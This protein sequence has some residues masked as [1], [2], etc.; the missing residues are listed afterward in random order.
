MN[1]LILLIGLVGVSEDSIYTKVYQ[2][3]AFISYLEIGYLEHGKD[4]EGQLYH[5]MKWSHLTGFSFRDEDGVWLLT[6]GHAIIYDINHLHDPHVAYFRSDTKKV[7]EEL[8]FIGYD[9][10]IDVSLFRFLKPEAVDGLPLARLGR[11]ENL[12]VGQEVISISCSG[13]LRFFLTKSVIAKLDFSGLYIGNKQ[14]QLIVHNC[15]IISGSSGSPL[16]NLEGEVIGLNVMVFKPQIMATT[17]FGL[18]VPIDDIKFLLKE[19]KR[20]GKIEHQ[21]TGLIIFANSADIYE[22]DLINRLNVPSRPLKEGVIIID[23][24]PDSQA[25]LSGFKPGDR[26]VACNG[27]EIKDPMEFLKMVFLKA[28]PYDI[29]KLEIDRYGQK[30]ILPLLLV[31][32]EKKVLVNECE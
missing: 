28:K 21:E 4:D 32:F 13:S 22:G 17:N 14:P 7:P 11:S 23:F 19:M 29:L 12:Q 27:V 25:A 16:L 20:G 31:D 18:A 24:K 6:A 5:Y 30:M 15:H 1:F 9:P 10:Y 2:Q 8:E 26:I 3:S